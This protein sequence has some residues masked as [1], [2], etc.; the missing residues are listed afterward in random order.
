M[1]FNSEYRPAIT[2]KKIGLINLSRTQN[3]SES[4][5]SEGSK[6]SKERS[7]TPP[8]PFDTPTTKDRILARINSAK[9][10]KLLGNSPRKFQTQ[11]QAQFLPDN[12]SQPKITR[13]LN[14]K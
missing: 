14:R 11:K 13:A 1:R 5:E 9:N 6:N 3:D 2:N 7:V 10:L 12:K 4:S 8:S